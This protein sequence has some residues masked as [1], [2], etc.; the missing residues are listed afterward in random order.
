MTTRP[1]SLATWIVHAWTRVYTQGLPSAEQR[2]R[3]AEIES[4]LWE[5]EHDPDEPKGGWAAIQVATRLIAGIPEDLAWRIDVAGNAHGA[6]VR[7]LAAAGSITGTRRVSAFGLAATIHIVVISTVMAF[8]SRGPIPSP[9]AGRPT[10][11]RAGGRQ[12]L[13]PNP[14]FWNQVIRH[15]NHSAPVMKKVTTQGEGPSATA[16]AFGAVRAVAVRVAAR[17]GSIAPTRLVAPVPSSANETAASAAQ[18]STPSDRFIAKVVQNRYSLSVQHGQLSGSG[19]PVLQSAI[20]QSRFVLL[21]EDHGIAETPAMGSAICNAPG[22]EPFQRMAIEEGPLAAAALESSTRRQDGLVQLAAFDRTF[23]Q[24]LNVYKTREE[25]DML[26]SCSRAARGEFHLWGLN[27]E[28]LGAGGLILT[29]ILETRLGDPARSAM[30]QLLQTNDAAY[31]RALQSGGIGD[32][33]MLSADDQDLARGAAALQRDGN[34]E[35]RS[36]FASLVESHEINRMSPADYDNARHRERLKKTQLAA[37]YRQAATSAA[38]P[39][40]V[41]LKFGGYHIYRGLNPVRG[42]GVG[43]YVSELAEAQGVQSLHIRLMPVKGSQPIY[44]RVG[45]PAQ[46]LPFNY[47]NDPGSRYL[48][49]MLSNRLA[50]DWTL[51]DLRPLRH[52][53]N[54]LLRGTNPELATLVFGIDLL[55]LV[56][57]STPSTE[58]H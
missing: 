1:L 26:Q 18:S 48:Q 19:A 9:T 47:D 38:T 36:L 15:D 21:G 20:A 8:A 29:R 3:R 52:D 41:L 57:E 42:S 35:A 13:S 46:L 49:P 45:Q 4:D 55:V 23:P 24:S 50:A 6:P 39:P 40:R 7:A 14:S 54:A 37:D 31:R 28:G 56:P 34:P 22:P 5:F 58:I 2:A 53:F 11:D 10:P 32:L 51:F 44:P 43:N 30:Q 27:Q 25:F 17:V 16:R 12:L 33:F